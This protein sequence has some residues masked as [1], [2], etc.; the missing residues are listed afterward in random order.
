MTAGRETRAIKCTRSWRQRRAITAGSP[1]LARDAVTAASG[2]MPQEPAASTLIS[3]AAA[4][5]RP[6]AAAIVGRV[7]ANAEGPKAADTRT[8]RPREAA[9][10]HRGRRDLARTARSC[11]S[12]DHRTRA[13]R[14][15][16]RCSGFPDPV[17]RNSLIW[18][19]H[20]SLIIFPVP[21]LPPPAGPIVQCVFPTSNQ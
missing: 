14:S 7:S 1:A 10:T 9:P 12:E 11:R 20:K 17:A 19:E 8:H 4:S 2:K 6:A 13:A 5:R 16:I 21:P 18:C 15:L 3:G